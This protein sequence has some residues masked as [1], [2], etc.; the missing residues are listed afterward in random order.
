M[1]FEPVLSPEQV[2]LCHGLSLPGLALRSS[3]KVCFGFFL[4]FFQAYPLVPCQ[5]SDRSSVNVYRTE[6]LDPPAM[7]ACLICCDLAFS[8]DFCDGTPTTVLLNAQ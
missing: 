8:F 5:V 3:S 6:M 1:N 7:E 2:L 4:F